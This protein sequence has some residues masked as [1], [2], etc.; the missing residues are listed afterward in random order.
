MATY[1][2]P[3]V[4]I[5]EIS[6]LPASVAAVETAIP[7]FIGI[8]E[9]AKTPGGENV[10]GKAIKISS[11]VD[12]QAIFGG[13]PPVISTETI[14]KIQLDATLQAISDTFDSPFYLYQSIFL[15]YANGGGDCYVV[16]VGTY[17]AADAKQDYLDGL[18]VVAKE[19]EPTLLVIPDLIRLATATDIYEVQQQMLKQCATLQDRFAVLD[20]FEDPAHTTNPLSENVQA[21]RSN[22]GLNNLKY[23]AAYTPY[24]KIG[25]PKSFSFEQIDDN[26]YKGDNPYDLLLATDSSV[27]ADTIAELRKDIKDKKE[28]NSTLNAPTTG[29]KDR[30]AAL[31]PPPGTV[32]PNFQAQWQFLKGEMLDG[33]ASP[34]AKVQ[35][36][37]DA[38]T[39][40]YECYH[41]FTKLENGLEAALLGDATG[42]VGSH[43]QTKLEDL[44]GLDLGAKGDGD[45]GAI[46]PFAG[47]QAIFEVSPADPGFYQDAS[48][49]PTALWTGLTFGGSPYAYA[50]T[51]ASEK[52]DDSALQGILDGIFNTF[53]AAWTTLNS[54]A[55][56]YIAENEK[57]LLNTFPV[58]RNIY[59]AVSKRP[60]FVP[61]SGAVV[62]AYAAVD[63]SRGVWK[64]PANVSLNNV[65]ALTE[66]I[67]NEEQQSLNVD[68]TGGK[69]INAIR[70]FKG[71]GHLIWGARTLAGNDNEWRYVPVRRLYNMVEESIKKATEH[72]VFEP[73]DAN[74]WTRVRAMIGNFL[75][76]LWRQGALAGAKPEE[77]FFV[78]VGLGLTMTAQDI[79][80]GRMI[81]EVGMAAVRPAEFIVLRFMHKLQE[82]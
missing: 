47:P 64:A 9:K 22:I 50:G 1:K 7:A 44:I 61:P 77:S 79:L 14:P 82:S 23:G 3:G 80:E 59:N 35:A 71:K 10:S 4:Y 48:Y 42:F 76:G 13:A 27:V 31:F 25:I 75:T 18:A 16:S 69:S 21:F 41:L 55:A 68:V 72:V 73:N 26:L 12:F 56:A 29:F 8:T 63:A 62:G 60:S 5:E 24:L 20:V 43:L 36:L 30:V 32:A 57:D 65:V 58:Y 45:I 28:L 51:S 19:D 70:F 46:P 54:N 6:T 17:G 39:Y 74:T 52:I 34:G 40:L 38:F 37:A 33:A 66:T 49:F 11:M 53:S 67:G 81:I 2:T 15:F 78:N